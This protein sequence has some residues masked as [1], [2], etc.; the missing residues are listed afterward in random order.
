M[1]S[2][3]LMKIGLFIAM[4]AALTARATALPEAYPYFGTQVYGSDDAGAAS[5]MI[6][7]IQF[8]FQEFEDLKNELE[9]VA[10]A[11]NADTNFET[12][13]SRSLAKQ[14]NFNY[15]VRN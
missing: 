7:R 8:N 5:S 9:S 6:E 13:R 10:R 14:T 4:A 15:M 2:T 1:S 3:K 12:P 11:S